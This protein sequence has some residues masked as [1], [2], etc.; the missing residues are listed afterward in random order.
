[1]SIYRKR[2]H[3]PQTTNTASAP[4]CTF[5]AETKMDVPN[6]GKDVAPPYVQPPDTYPT[7][8][9]VYP[10]QQQDVYTYINSLYIVMEQTLTPC[11]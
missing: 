9:S 8:A 3:S 11:Y 5:V 4:P 1:M 10:P 7:Y 6:L 2:N